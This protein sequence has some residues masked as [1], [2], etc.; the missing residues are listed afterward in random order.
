MNSSNNVNFIVSELVQHP[1]FGHWHYITNRLLTLYDRSLEL[2]QDL[3]PAAGVLNNELSKGGSKIRYLISTDPIFRRTIDH[4]IG[5][6]NDP[7][8]QEHNG[9]QFHLVN[10]MCIEMTRLAKEL[11]SNP[12]CTPMQAFGTGLGDDKF[13]GVPPFH[14]VCWH[15][16][17]VETPL[18]VASR[19]Q[20]LFDQEIAEGITSDKAIM[21]SLTPEF[22]NILNKGLDI[23]HLVSPELARDAL[24][25]VKVLGIVDRSNYQTQGA[26]KRY[27]LCQNVSTHRIPGTIF[28]SPTPL[29]HPL[30]AAEAV[31]H[32]ALHKKLSNIVST[33]DIFTPRYDTETAP[34]IPAIW[35]PDLSWNSNQWPIDR[36]L[37]ALHFYAHISV[38]YLLFDDEKWEKILTEHG[39]PGDLYIETKVRKALDRA[40]YLSDEL[41]KIQD[42]FLGDAGQKLLAWLDS[43]CEKTDSN[44][45]LQDPRPILRLD[46]YD[47]ETQEIVALLK[48]LPEEAVFH[49]TAGTE[50]WTIGQTIQHLIHSEIVSAYRIL[51]TLGQEKSPVFS[52]YDGDS[53]G[54]VIGNGLSPAQNADIFK[55][56]RQ[57]TSTTLRKSAKD[58]DYQRSYRSTGSKRTLHD[59]LEMAVQHVNNHLPM[60]KRAVLEWKKSQK[61]G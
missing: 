50:G 5:L 56:L 11:K 52:W 23:L 59:L 53:W 15:P 9:H 17:S 46:L 13:I 32:E 45:P 14:I 22:Q 7:N 44:P 48:S 26:K 39:D 55:A 38:Y 58:N 28:L 31:L 20:A 61:K 60:L 49:P 51:M 37:Y 24:S 10:E 6:N 40:H 29:R 42:G 19:F 25:H 21:R 35:N 18:D 30:H 33:M 16:Q 12:A 41:S 27:D 1:Q 54:Q 3:V 47:R 2:L 43:I 8:S 36:A 57:F 34:T 4:A